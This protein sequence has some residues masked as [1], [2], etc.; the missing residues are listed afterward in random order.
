MEIITGSGIHN[1]KLAIYLP[2]SGLP[3]RDGH[4]VKQ[5]AAFHQRLSL[6]RSRSLPSSSCWAPDEVSGG[7][8]YTNFGVIPP[9][10]RHSPLCFYF[11]RP[12]VCFCVSSSAAGVKK[13][14]GAPLSDL[15]FS[16]FS[17]GLKLRQ[18]GG[19]ILGLMINVG[20]RCFTGTRT[21]THA[22]VS[23]L[24]HRSRG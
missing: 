9:R 2:V 17:F 6:S 21:R 7:I 3:P 4:R 23:E 14:D 18:R 12:R 24:L 16:F 10:L 22:T 13:I 5:M 11:P 19:W 20:F 15:N 8:K 1:N